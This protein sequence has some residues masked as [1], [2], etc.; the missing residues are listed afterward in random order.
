MTMK[1]GVKGLNVRILSGAK[2]VISPIVIV[3]SHFEALK[4][5]LLI[6]LKHTIKLTL[7]PQN[8]YI[9]SGHKNSDVYSYF[10][11][12]WGGG[13]GGGLGGPEQKGAMRS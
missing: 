9:A 2:A 13:P 8:A 5:V 11:R 4:S 1:A 12:A 7:V 6:S 3:G 10:K